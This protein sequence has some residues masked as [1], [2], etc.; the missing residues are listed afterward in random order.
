MRRAAM[1]VA[2][3]AVLLGTTK[4]SAQ[5]PNFSGTWTRIVDPNA[6]AMGGGRGGGG[7]PMTIT[8]DAKT[9]TITRTT[10]NGETKTVYNLDG[11]DSKNTMNMGGNSVDVMSKAKWDGGKLKVT[12]EQEFNGNKTTTTTQYSLDSSG[13][14]MVETTRPPRGGGDPVTTTTMY[15][16]G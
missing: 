2:A 9:L 16:K 6:P 5:S 15:K 12:T 14:L 4:L 10:Q 1:L 11:S 7:G 8:Q 13:N 3:A